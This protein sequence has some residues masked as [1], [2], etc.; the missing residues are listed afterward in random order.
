M[1]LLEKYPEISKEW[2]YKKNILKPTDFKPYSNKRVHWI[3]KNGHEWEAIISNRT[4]QNN[5]CPICFKNES[6]CENFIFQTLSQKFKIIKLEKT[7]ENP[8]IDIYLPDL[9]IGIEYDGFYHKFRI[10]SDILK[11]TWANRNLNLL[12]R[13]R[14][15]YLPELPNCDKILIIKQKNSSKK[16]TEESLSKICQILKIDFRELNLNVG[17]ESKIRNYQLPEEIIK[18]W[19]IT[20]NISIGRALKTHKYKWI[21]DKCNSE[22]EST[23]RNRL[24]GTNCPFCASQKVNFENSIS[25]THP[26][27]LK[28][29]SKYNEVDPNTIT[30]GTG[31]KLR[32]LINSREYYDTPRN[33]NRILNRLNGN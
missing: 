33:F 6:W 13:I 9:K 28:Y 21:C 27:I 20:N 22:Y 12:I 8:E 3:C 11:N 15:Q 14:E 16:S 17:I 25:K 1:N 32:F 30:Y 24:K 4:K 31:K 10:D 26:Q 29:I 7:K 19:S 18:S 5:N 2:N 23:L